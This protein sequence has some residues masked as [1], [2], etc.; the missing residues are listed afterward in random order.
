MIK[1]ECPRVIHHLL[2]VTFGVH[3]GVSFSLDAGDLGQ[4]GRS[5]GAD[6]EKSVKRTCA[7]PRPDAAAR[8]S[9]PPAADGCM[10]GGLARRVAIQ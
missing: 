10:A 7:R 6:K 9:G 3:L 8:P 5:A 4:S 1:F 2:S